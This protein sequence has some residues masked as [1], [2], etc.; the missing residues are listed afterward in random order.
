VTD[1][2]YKY[3]EDKLIQEIKDY[4]DATYHM[5]YV[6]EDNIQSMDLI[7]ATGHATGF[8]IGSIFKYAG[9]FGKK[10]GYNRKDLLKIIHYAMF[11][12]YNQDK[13]NAVSTEATND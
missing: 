6:G 10:E 9:R 3:R 7:L 2:P 13:K 4:V 1:I 8:N 5:H 12:L 11:E